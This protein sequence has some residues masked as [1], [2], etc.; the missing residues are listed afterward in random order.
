MTEPLNAKAKAGFGRAAQGIGRTAKAASA[1]VTEQAE[2]VREQTRK[3]VGK[4]KAKDPDPYELA[5]AE[6][7]HVFTLMSDAGL[8]ILRQ[9]ERSVDLIELVEHLVNSIANTPKSFNAD[10]EEI[11][12]NKEEFQD[13]LDFAQKDLEAARRSVST[14][15]AG[16]AAG[17]A[18]ASLAPSAALWAATTFGTASTGT[19]ISALTGAAASKAAI[20]WLGGGALAAGGGGMAA[21]NALLALAGPIG[22]G[23]SGATLL[24]SMVIYSRSKAANRKEK[25]AALSD[26]KTNTAALRRMDAQM[27]VLLTQ[28]TEL[29]ER[30]LQQYRAALVCFDSDFLAL[31]SERQKQMAALVNNTKACAAL[32]SEH[33]E[34]EQEKPEANQ[35]AEDSAG[36]AADTEPALAPINSDA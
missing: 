15:G 6:Y 1:Q 2:D 31:T 13:L 24:G 20:A 18:V 32:L 9:R 5:V 35:E 28:T 14:T 10:F 19:A 16:L 30:L 23:I 22:W 8:S 25:E 3:T 4:L 33:I 27:T 36:A 7:N 17:V 34:A 12:V 11:D 26:V 29:R 21:G